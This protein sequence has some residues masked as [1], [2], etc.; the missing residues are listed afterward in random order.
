[1][2]R[3]DALSKSLVDAVLELHRRQ[4]WQSNG[5]DA[6]FSVRLPGESDPAI[7][8]ISGHGGAH[9]G[10][11]VAHGPRAWPQML[12]FVADPDGLPESTVDATLLSVTMDTLSRLPPELRQLL[13]RA[14][15]SARRDSL[16]PVAMV[17]DGSDSFL[18]PNRTQMRVLLSVI[19][20]ILRAQDSGAF[21]PPRKEQGER[22][23]LELTPKGEGR[24][25][26]V[27]C[28]LVP[29]PE[30]LVISDPL[31][32]SLKDAARGLTR[33]DERWSV[34]IV[35]VR[36][37]SPQSTGTY[38]LAV[39]RRPN[40][41]VLAVAPVV[42]GDTERA[43]EQLASVMLGISRRDGVRGVPVE[44]VFDNEGLA[45]ACRSEMVKLGIAVKFDRTDRFLDS[46]RRDSIAEESVDVLDAG[47][48]P[49]IGPRP[50][51]REEWKKVDK[52]VT[53]Q[54][55]EETWRNDPR[56]KKALVKFFGSRETAGKV[57]NEF[58]NYDPMASFVEWFIADYRVTSRSKT[59]VETFLAK[60][61]LSPWHRE[62][63]EARRQARFSVYRV[64]RTEPGSHLVVE[65]VLDGS[66]HTVH[67]RSLASL[68]YAG[69]VLPMRLYA[70]DQWVFPALGGPPLPE[71]GAERALLQLESL[72]V[73]LTPKGMRDAGHLLGS[74][75]QFLL[76]RRDHSPRIGNSDGDP[77]EPQT[78]TFNVK[79]VKDL[80][81]AL[82]ERDDVQF[83]KHE[84]E[85]VWFRTNTS[86][87]DAGKDTLLGRLNLMD[88]TLVVELNSAERLRR[89]RLWLDKLPGVH[90]RS[91]KSEAWDREDRPLDDRLKGEPEPP[92]SPEIQKLL[93]D[94]V[95]HGALR[96]LDACVPLLGGLTPRQACKTEAGRR[97]VGL[98]IRTM[99]SVITPSGPIAPPRAQLLKELGLSSQEA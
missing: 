35:S 18:P 36:A 73:E 96:W 80:E 85:W 52:L 37:P 95:R 41:D 99:P 70:V 51:T 87:P 65:D 54:L 68:L 14:R 44:I 78:A 82:A 60:K 42:V 89:I 34:G 11:I 76:D 19:R 39:L 49:R 69:V 94:E 90:F 74:L 17:L 81:K 9:Y 13:E 59:V 62:V 28:R 5:G 93:E 1:M 29:A 10:L 77:F 79:N 91:A 21:R 2:D 20:T 61:S 50:R 83:D 48:A 31:Q 63:L 71:V 66:M 7:V 16:V 47:D 24:E 43:L 12:R 98:M 72:G 75:W 88:D 40:A 30:P 86:G 55:I 92:P 64:H 84:G 3:P 6:V 22:Q 26:T 45:D 23:I 8:T 97:R 38:G 53:D 67:D 46:F 33:I 25:M 15:H 56:A 58:K 57:L 27:E 32:P 4:L